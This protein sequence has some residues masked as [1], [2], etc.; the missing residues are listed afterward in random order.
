MLCKKI[1]TVGV[2]H[3]QITV[4]KQSFTGFKKCIQKLL[5]QGRGQAEGVCSQRRT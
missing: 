1:H 2:M 5:L 4:V 3:V